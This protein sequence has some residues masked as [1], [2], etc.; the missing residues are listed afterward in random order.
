MNR[1]AVDVRWP[2][3][4]E[5]ACEWAQKRRLT[6]RRTGR[7][8]LS[9]SAVERGYIE[10]LQQESMLARGGAVASQFAGMGSMSQRPF[11]R[12][13][14][15]AAIEKASV[16][17][18]AYPISMITRAGE[19]FL[20]MLASEDLWRAFGLSGSTRCTPDR[21]S[22][23]A[24]SLAGRHTQRGRAFRPDQHS[25]SMRLSEL[26]PSSGRCVQVA[27]AHGHHHR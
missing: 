18:T 12:S 15:R 14:P 5:L 23:P 22:G 11:A 9:E 16:W 2:A 26:R 6:R 4:V 25:G 8:E 13:D 20:C 27:A 24:A 3:G 21:S 17:F 19:S 1:D 10:W 7:V